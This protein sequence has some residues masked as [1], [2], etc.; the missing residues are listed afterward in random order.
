MGR[1]EERLASIERRHASESSTLRV[2]RFDKGTIDSTNDNFRTSL[3]KL[4]DQRG[5]H[6]VAGLGH[7][8]R[9]LSTHA[10]NLYE[11]TL[12]IS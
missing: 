3:Q 4:D 2:K 8:V 6:Y 11:P 12:H 9:G 5:N 10:L 1:I 7:F